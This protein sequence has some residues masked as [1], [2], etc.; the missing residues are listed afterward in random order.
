MHLSDSCR[1]ETIDKYCAQQCHKL[2][3]AMFLPR[4]HSID[5][6]PFWHC[7]DGTK[8]AQGLL[9]SQP[10]V[11]LMEATMYI[12]KTYILYTSVVC[13]KMSKDPD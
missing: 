6:I 9:Y 1:S 2:V 13:V 5:A 10:S 8:E 12:Q 7:T 11:V 4:R 3:V